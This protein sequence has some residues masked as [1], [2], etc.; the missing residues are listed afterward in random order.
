MSL[1]QPETNVKPR[2]DGKGTEFGLMHRQLGPGYLMFDID[3][4]F[5]TVQMDLALK[6]EDEGWVE[7]RVRNDAV[8]FI[9]MMEL[10]KHRTEHSEKALDSKE[11]NSRA[12][13]EIAR[14]LGCRLF[15]VFGTNGRQPFDFYEV[16]TSDGEAIH[17][18][19]LCYENGNGTQAW[20]DFWS[21]TLRISK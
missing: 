7:Y 4:M 12:R 17:V 18:G 13:L 10:K 8:T 1:L 14:R 9:A 6:K 11:A 5:A 20:R 3:R 2:Y 21:D 16:N 15:V 19:T